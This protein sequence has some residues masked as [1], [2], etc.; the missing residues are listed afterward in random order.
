MAWQKKKDKEKRLKEEEEHKNEEKGIKKKTMS[1]QD[2][3]I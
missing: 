1:M 2:K 3:L